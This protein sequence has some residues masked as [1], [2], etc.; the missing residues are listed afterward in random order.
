MEVT[1]I[2][3]SHAKKKAERNTVLWKE[4]LEWKREQNSSG[5]YTAGTTALTTVTDK[6]HSDGVRG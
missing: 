2:I 4:W 6:G 1:K 3:L 5:D